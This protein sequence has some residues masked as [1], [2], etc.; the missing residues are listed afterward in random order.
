M[1]WRLL[2][3]VLA[4]CL[5]E[6]RV[7]MQQNE[8]PHTHVFRN[9][10]IICA[11][12]H[13]LLNAF[14]THVSC[15]NSMKPSHNSIESSDIHVSPISIVTITPHNHFSCPTMFSRYQRILTHSHKVRHQS[16]HLLL[17]ITSPLQSLTTILMHCKK[18]SKHSSNIQHSVS[19][20]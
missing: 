7:P 12:A 20:V 15:T 11:V 18:S 16:S 14:L 19:P 3:C 17:T 10:V 13:L 8:F 6:A 2:R 5:H 1:H 4:G 9:Y